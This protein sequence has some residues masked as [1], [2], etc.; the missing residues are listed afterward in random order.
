MLLSHVP[1]DS[2]LGGPSPTSLVPTPVRACRCG[3]ENE[4]GMETV[5]LHLIGTVALRSGCISSQAFQLGFGKPS[6]ESI[7]NWPCF[8][9]CWDLGSSLQGFSLHIW[10]GWTGFLRK[11]ILLLLIF[12]NLSWKVSELHLQGEGLPCVRWIPRGAWAGMCCG[13]CRASGSASQTR[14]VGEDGFAKEQKHILWGG[15]NSWDL[16]VFKYWRN[17]PGSLLKT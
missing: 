1:L 17:P 2:G 16:T 10:I 5:G 8:V 12:R 3:T 14:A 6:A 9:F 4:E 15:N 13:A 7:Q 11:V